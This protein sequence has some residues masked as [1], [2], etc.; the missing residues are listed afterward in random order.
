MLDGDRTKPWAAY[1][2]DMA[3]TPAEYLELVNTDGDFNFP[4]YTYGATP[5]PD[6]DVRTH[7]YRVR[8]DPETLLVDTAFIDDPS[9][10]VS[11]GEL[12][13]GSALVTSL[14][15]GHAHSGWAPHGAYGRGNVDLRGTPFV[16]AEAA[17]VVE[18]YLAN[19]SATYSADRK[20]VNLTG[21]GHCGWIRAIGD[22]LQLEYAE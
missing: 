1:C 13:E 7:Y 14:R 16:V 6:D 21:G 5:N 11:S 4:Q 10:S 3:G 17:F 15:Y 2:H 18:G 22:H 8:I 20:I 12:N 9:F 19:G